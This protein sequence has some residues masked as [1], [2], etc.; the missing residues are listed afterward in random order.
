MTRTNLPV[1]LL[2]GIVLLPNNDIKMEFTRNESDIIVS[3]AEFFHNNKIL[4]VC[5]TEDSDSK[6]FL[7][8]E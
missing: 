4:I 1:I 2:K 8:V 7:M 3:E 5:D 6:K